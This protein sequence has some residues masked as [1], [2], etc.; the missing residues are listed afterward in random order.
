MEL[1][2]PIKDSLPEEISY[3]EVR[4]VAAHLRRKQKG[5]AAKA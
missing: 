5:A 3:D 2:K 4:L 1:L